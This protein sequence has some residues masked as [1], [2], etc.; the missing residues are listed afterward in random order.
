MNKRKKLKKTIVLIALGDLSLNIIYWAKELGLLTIVTNRDK[1]AQSM[2]IADV[3]L[4]VDGNDITK[5]KRELAKLKRE[6][7]IIGIYTCLE[8]AK[9]VSI[10]GKF[11][12]LPVLSL[13]T[14]TAIENKI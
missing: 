6:Y 8:L 12:N 3:P 1:N 13:K 7:S 2:K 5:L 11:L 14:A 9:T 4:N 10:V